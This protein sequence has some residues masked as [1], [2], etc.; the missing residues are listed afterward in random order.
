MITQHLTELRELL[1]LS[2]QGLSLKAGLSKVYVSQ[3]ELNRVNPSIREVHK[4]ALALHHKVQIQSNKE[5][6]L[7]PTKEF[8]AK[9]K[10]NPIAI[11]TKS[12]YEVDVDCPE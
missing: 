7:K 12:K 2:R 8:Y 6:L 10:V 1:G 9:I 11:V 4:L 3:M 5:I